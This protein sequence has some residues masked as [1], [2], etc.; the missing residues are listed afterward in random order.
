MWIRKFL[1]WLHVWILNGLDPN[2]QDIIEINRS[3]GFGVDE[4]DV[5]IAEEY[6]WIHKQRWQAFHAKYPD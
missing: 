2:W 1:A 5:K 4:I 3:I 6:D